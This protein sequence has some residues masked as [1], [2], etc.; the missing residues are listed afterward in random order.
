V[1]GK[2]R[3]YGHFGGFVV[4]N[5]ADHDYVGVSAQKT[6]HG[7]GK[8]KTDF[9]I[10]LDLSEAWLSDFDRVFRGPNLFVDCIDC[11][12]RGVERSRF[13]RARRADA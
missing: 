3:F 5:L 4:T 13:P 7:G 12:E 6:A 9:M 1:T 10:Y 8:V 11:A 2:R